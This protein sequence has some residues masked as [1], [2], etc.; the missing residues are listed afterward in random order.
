MLLNGTLFVVDNDLQ[1]A[2][3][4][5]DVN[6]VTKVVSVGSSYL[7]PLD[8]AT[9]TLATPMTLVAMQGISI[10]AFDEGYGEPPLFF[11]GEDICFKAF[12]VHNG[13]PVTPD[14]HEI[15]ITVKSSK[16]AY[17]IAWSG[18][19]HAGATYTGQPGVYA[20]RIPVVASQDWLA[21]TYWMSVFGELLS[22][23]E[24]PEVRR[25][26]LLCNSAF[27]LDYSPS[28]PNPENADASTEI[29]RRRP[30][31]ESTMPIPARTY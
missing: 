5:L 30:L 10:S 26:T 6:P 7:L 14:T 24:A 21:G 29:S 18:D 20:I 17:H 8:R 27:L 3:D 28:S 12:L 31:L 23:T 19:T 15:K 1:T 13:E 25:Q 11:Q 9:G 22:T 16:Y 2:H 4:V